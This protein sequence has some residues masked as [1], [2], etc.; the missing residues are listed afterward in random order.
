MG[1][2]PI[3]F[4]K[5]QQS[6]TH[7]MRNTKKEKRSKKLDKKESQHSKYMN[8]KLEFEIGIS[9]YN[10]QYTQDHKTLLLNIIDA[11]RSEYPGFKIK[12][13][14]YNNLLNLIN[15][16]K[17]Y[18]ESNISLN[19][20]QRFIQ[21]SLTYR[22]LDFTLVL[23]EIIHK[24][25]YKKF[26]QYD[27]FEYLISVEHIRHLKFDL[28]LG[29][30]KKHKSPKGS[31]YLLPSLIYPGRNKVGLSSHAIDRIDE[32][33]RRLWGTAEKCSEQTNIYLWHDPTVLI[34]Y[35][36][37]IYGLYSFSMTHT[38]PSFLLVG[39]IP[40]EQHDSKLI[41]LT[42]L[43]PGFRQTPE[44]GMTEKEIKDTRLISI[45]NNKVYWPRDNK[46]IECDLY[47]NI[48]ILPKLVDICKNT[49][50]THKIVGLLK[51]H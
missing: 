31:M 22:Q 40:I 6:E 33:F 36:N 10:D 13:T 8:K 7:T 16:R 39:Y 4:D 20:L 44:Y 17:S 1:N 48:N 30:V 27:S 2:R 28:N 29:I 9:T 47:E 23:Q 49:V 19:K 32:R 24:A 3:T 21:T 15:S 26:P 42:Y 41:G 12:D 34:P 14:F 25:L 43:P 37:D 38:H 5:T 50:D 35:N 18:G 45:I 46:Y 51:V 11:M